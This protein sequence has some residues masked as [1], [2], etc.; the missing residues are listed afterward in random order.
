MFKGILVEAASLIKSVCLA[1]NAGIWIISRTSDA[2]ATSST[3]CT[4]EIIGTLN[5]SFKLERILRPS[6]TPGPL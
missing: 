6:L 2:L 3:V 4:S 1:K 5:S